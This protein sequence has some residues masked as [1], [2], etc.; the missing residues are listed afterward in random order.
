MSSTM[1]FIYIFL[2]LVLPLS[3]SAQYFWDIGFRAGGAN[4]L[5]EIGG[6]DQAKRE[7]IYDIKLSQTR[8]NSGLFA[9]YRLSPN[10]AITT[11]INYMRVQGADSLT[12]YPVRFGRNLSF[13]N[14][15][16]ETYTRAEYSFFGVSDVG[17]TGRYRLDFKSYV[18]IGAALFYNNPKGFYEGKWHA[19]QPLNTEQLDTKYSRWQPSIPLGIGFYYTFKRQ[20]RFGWEFSWRITFTDYIDDASTVFA[21]PDEFDSELAANL[22][23]RSGEQIDDPRHPG[24]DK[25]APGAIRGNPDSKDSY[26]TTSFTYSYVLRGSGRSFGKKKYNYLYG[27]RRKGGRTRAKF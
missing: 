21:D 8:W 20:H 25:Y 18:F 14:D 9:R 17:R 10:V 5:G 2:V 15:I 7:W 27:K 11:G 26:L 16:V 24:I 12:D 23:N 3:G 6:T 13:R 19:L 4:Y 22:A 1:R